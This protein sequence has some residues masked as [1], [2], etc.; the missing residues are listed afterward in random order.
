[1]T[2]EKESPKK[3][4]LGQAIDEAIDALGPLGEVDRITAIRAVCE[5]LNIPLI[6]QIEAEISPKTRLTEIPTKRPEPYALIPESPK[7]IR[8]LKEQK[9]PSA[10]TEMATIVA[11]YLM[12]LAPPEDRKETITRDDI[13]KY[14]KQAGYPLPKA[15]RMV[16]PTA[17]RAGYLEQI[18]E[19]EYKLNPVGYNLVVHS[20]PRKTSPPPRKPVKKKTSPKK[21]SK[22]SSRK[23]TKKK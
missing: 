4:T 20:L 13:E 1:M 19:G 2:A 3:K 5:H 14:F 22:K 23:K 16:L 9:Q 7:D 12:E 17:K 21:P 15:I 11:Y 18:A 10:A 6:K 8:T